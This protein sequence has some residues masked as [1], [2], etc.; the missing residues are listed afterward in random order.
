MSE[1][2]TNDEIDALLE[3]FQSEGLP[4]DI[5]EA[6]EDIEYGLAQH[7]KGENVSEV[8]LLKPNRFTREHLLVIEHIQEM[9]ARKVG[10]TISERLR[11]DAVCDCVAVEQLRFSTWMA[12]LERPVAVYMLQVEPMG[13]SAV[14]SVSS[15]LLYGAVDCIMGGAGNVDSIPKDLSEAEYC[16][17]E[18]FIQPVLEEIGRGF[19]EFVQLRMQVVGRSTNPNMAQVLPMGEVVLALHYQ[20]SGNPLFGDIKFAIPFTCLESHLAELERSRFMPTLSNVGAFRD[21]IS[22]TIE[23]VNMKLSVNL[24]RTDLKLGD[25]LSLGVG[26]VIT[27]RTRPGDLLEIPVQDRPKFMGKV[28][29]QGKRYAVRIHDVLHKVRR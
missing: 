2:L 15:R 19:E 25:L 10:G 12:Q 13:F 8:D 28:G 11:V 7:S 1:L 6:A 4:E 23:E 18:S 26:D 29:V 22:E 5:A 3:I 9:V 17:A 14:L 21:V 24:G 20:L 27:L 16:V